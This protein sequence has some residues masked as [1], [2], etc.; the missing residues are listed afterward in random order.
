MKELPY[1]KFEPAEWVIGD[2]SLL[3]YEIKGLFIDI[4]CFYWMKVGA[5]DKQMLNKRFANAEQ[6]LNKLFDEKIIKI[7]AKK[8]KVC[9]EFLDVQLAKF[10]QLSEIRSDA[11]KQGGKAKQ[12]NAKQ[13]LSKSKANDNIKEEKRI[14]EIIYTFDHLK[15]N[16]EDFE[17]L[18]LE[19]TEKQI[20]EV[21]EKIQNYKNNKNYKSLYLTAKNWLKKDK[22]QFDENKLHEYITYPSKF[23]GIVIK[24]DAVGLHRTFMNEQEGIEVIKQKIKERKLQK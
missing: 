11:G 14:E 7:D 2:I 18:K 8:E 21:F 16:K 1:F 20:Y 9:I 12:A 15:I 24:C 19:Y 4:C 3:D 23:E 13:M 6:M 17:K 10:M 22:P 5:I